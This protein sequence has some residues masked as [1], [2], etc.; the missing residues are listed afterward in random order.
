MARLPKGLK[1]LGLSRQPKRARSSY[2]LWCDTVRSS[3]LLDLELEGKSMAIASK[4]LSARWKQLTPEE[5]RPFEEQSRA[6]KDAF[7]RAQTNETAAVTSDP[8]LLPEGWKAVRDVGT[9]LVGYTCVATGRSQWHRPGAEDA[10]ALPPRPVSA[11]R[12]FELAL[13]RDGLALP[14]KEVTA[15]W[16]ALPPETVRQHEAAARAARG[17]YKQELRSMRLNLAEET[18]GAPQPPQ[19]AASTS[20]QA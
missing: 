13:E 20:P 16:R 7:K 5:K 18:P 10:V 12:A 4:V 1:P 2:F 14:A 17:V 8:P 15:R 6:L 19:A 11:R 9:D 3:S